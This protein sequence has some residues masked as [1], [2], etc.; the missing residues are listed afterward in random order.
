MATN[1]MRSY[2]TQQSTSY[3]VVEIPDDPVTVA[4]I[5]TIVGC[6]LSCWDMSTPDPKRLPVDKETLSRT[7][8]K[9]KRYFQSDWL[10]KHN[11]LVLCKT[12]V[13]AYC[14][15]CRYA[16]STKLEVFTDWKDGSKMSL[17]HESSK[18]HKQA[19]MTIQHEL[20]AAPINQQI[21]ESTKN[22]HDDRRTC[23]EE[24]VKSLRY[25]ARQGLPIRNSD[26][27]NG[28]L[29]QLLKLSENCNMKRYLADNNYLSHHIN[30]EL[31]KEM[32]RLVMKRLLD[33]IKSAS[34]FSIVIDEARDI[35]GIEQ[36][37]VVLRWVSD[38]YTVFEDVIGF[39][40]A[41]LC[42]ADSIV[43]IIKTVLLSVGLDIQ[44]LRGQTYDGASVLQGHKTG[45]AKQI[46]QI[47]PK[48]LSTHCLNHSLNL[49]LQ[50]AASTNDIVSGAFTAVQS[51]CSIIRASP[52]RLAVFKKIQIQSVI[53]GSL[54]HQR[55]L[56]PLCETRWTCRTSSLCSILDNY[57]VIL[58]TLE[59]VTKSGGS[60]KGAKESPQLLCY[61]EKFSTVFGLKMCLLLFSP[62]ENMATQLQSKQL[63]ASAVKTIK[64]GLL[65][66][67]KDMRSDSFFKELY[68]SSKTMCQE[69]EFEPPTLPRRIRAP[70]KITK[71]YHGV[72][73]R[74]HGCDTP[75]KYYKTQFFSVIDS[76]TNKIE[77]R[78][79]QETLNYL[80]SLEDLTISAAKGDEF[81]I[82][83][84]VQENL[85]G[86][87]DVPKLSSE[88]N[89]LASFVKEVQPRKLRNLAGKFFLK[90]KLKIRFP[91]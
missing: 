52:K 89:L 1:T 14:Q 34:F 2:F 28:N 86:D 36:L 77:Q 32:Y 56:K 76:M 40:Q 20:R 39:H 45:V 23:L 88:L 16:V 8:G 87:V 31:I 68:N 5:P 19:F 83:E 80:I 27:E 11:W 82:T 3:G 17:R 60:T 67:L 55:S 61:L 7:Y 65:R 29:T 15:L 78:F 43:K 51:I 90:P 50:E 35:S 44:Q 22:V 66:H 85:E 75:E 72:P 81:H 84:T 21:E 70:K 18:I 48:A 59:E 91:Q 53:G 41:D 6:S 49:I 47:N 12:D 71:D 63:D 13:R 9:R 26:E 62:T 4:N 25:L 69:L 10:E 37:V 30:T 54:L 42:D 79:D 38:D 58:E 24:Q 64:S 74:D 73:N 46:L 57:E 33:Q